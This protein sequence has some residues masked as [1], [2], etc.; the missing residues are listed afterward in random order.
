MFA[1]AAAQSQYRPGGG[2]SGAGGFGGSGGGSFGGGA[3]GFGDYDDAGAGGAGGDLEE[4]IPGVPGDDYPIYAE[5]PD[6]SFVCDG[7]AEVANC[8]TI[9]WSV[10]K[11]YVIKRNSADY[12]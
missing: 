11:A 2:S 5:V 1:G 10:I 7:Q 12:L 3:G 6:T 4:N 8:V 9:T